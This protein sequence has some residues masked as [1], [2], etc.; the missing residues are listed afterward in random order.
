MCRSVKVNYVDNR[1]ETDVNEP[2]KQQEDNMKPVAF[3]EFTSANGWE[4]L[5][6]DSYIVLAINELIE[7]KMLDRLPHR[8]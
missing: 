2:Q 1:D 4:A 6:P 7:R 8:I 3:A 5:Q